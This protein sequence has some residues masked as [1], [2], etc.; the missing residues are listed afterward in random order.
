MTIQLDLQLPTKLEVK[1]GNYR[2]DVLI[3][4]VLAMNLTELKI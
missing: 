4:W 2:H 1:S 3:L